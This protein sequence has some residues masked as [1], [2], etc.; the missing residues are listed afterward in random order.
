MENSVDVRPCSHEACGPNAGAPLAGS[1]STLLS[2]GARLD[3]AG[4][5]SVSTTPR[6]TPDPTGRD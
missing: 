1:K 5:G 3:S 2:S 4:G 6:S